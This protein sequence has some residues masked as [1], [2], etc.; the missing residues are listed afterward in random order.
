MRASKRTVPAANFVG[1]VA[2]NVDNTMLSDREFRDFVRKTLPIVIYDPGR[3]PLYGEKPLTED[4]VG[5]C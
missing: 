1:T 4:S 3:L 2:A 5:T